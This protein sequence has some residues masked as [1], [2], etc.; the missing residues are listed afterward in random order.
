MSPRKLKVVRELSDRFN[1]SHECNDRDVSLLEVVSDEHKGRCFMAKQTIECGQMVLS[2]KPYA[3]IVDNNNRMKVCGYCFNIDH[4]AASDFKLPY[5]T[6]DGLQMVFYCSEQCKLAH[7]KVYKLESEFLQ[8]LQNNAVYQ[9]LSSYCQEYLWLL[10]RCLIN[11]DLEL[12]GDQCH[13]KQFKN[14]VTFQDV[15]SLVSNME[16]FTQ[17]RVEGEFMVIADLLQDLQRDLQSPPLDKSELL[18]LIC[19]EE[20]NSFGLYTFTE[21]GKPKQCYGLALYPLAVFFNHSCDPN[22]SHTTQGSCQVFYANRRIWAGEELTISYIDI[23]KSR[24]ERQQELKDVF[25]FECSCQRCAMGTAGSDSDCR[26]RSL[27]PD[28]SCYGSLLPISVDGLPVNK[29]DHQ[30]ESLS[31]NDGQIWQCECCQKRVRI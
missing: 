14:D 25:L 5:S 17:D 16:T 20:C 30:S 15:E 18:Q 1:N 28:T 29:A 7:S 21:T 23:R 27:C 31:D 9:E 24:A 11:R 12:Q 2:A 26:P 8:R 19:K 13:T 22:V 4:V 6:D 10:A 3:L